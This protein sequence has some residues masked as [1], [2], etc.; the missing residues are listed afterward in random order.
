MK[1]SCISLGKSLFSIAFLGDFAFLKRIKYF[2]LIFMGVSENLWFVLD[3][4]FHSLGLNVAYGEE[5]KIFIFDNTSVLTIVQKYY[6]AIF[7]Q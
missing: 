7:H 5:E 2:F 4:E 3:N 1:A 6:L